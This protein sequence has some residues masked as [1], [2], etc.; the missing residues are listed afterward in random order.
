MQ[1]KRYA[2]GRLSPTAAAQAD[3]RATGRAT[4]ARIAS[5]VPDEDQPLAR[6]RDRRVEQLA[7]EHAARSGRAAAPRRCRTASPGS[8]GWSSRRRVSTAASRAGLN[9]ATSPRRSNAALARPCSVGDDDAGVAVVE[10]QPVVVLGDQQRAPGVPAALGAEAVD[11]LGE[12]ALDPRRPRRDAVAARAGGRTAPGT[13][14]ARRAPP[15]RR[16]RARRR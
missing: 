1:R 14:R 8:C 6:A 13:R 2:S 7:G 16:R 12:P 3:A 9:R 4:A 11:L 10:P 5:S 15:R